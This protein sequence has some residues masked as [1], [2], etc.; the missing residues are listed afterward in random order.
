MGT[1]AFLQ[2]GRGKPGLVLPANA[3]AKINQARDRSAL[4][5]AAERNEALVD[6]LPNIGNSIAAKPCEPEPERF[7]EQDM[8]PQEVFDREE[9]KEP[10]EPVVK[11]DLTLITGIGPAQQRRLQK[12][13]FK[14]YGDLAATSSGTLNEIPGVKGRGA[15]IIESAR[16]LSEP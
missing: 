7:D 5:R 6:R 4:V 8:I 3:T 12:F 15:S 11:D 13:G 14:N 9:L 1:K 2:K 16:K 10:P